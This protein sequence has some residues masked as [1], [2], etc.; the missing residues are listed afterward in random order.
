MKKL[1]PFTITAI[2]ITSLAVTPALSRSMPDYNCSDRAEACEKA[3]DENADTGK[4][5]NAYNECLE[6]CREFVRRCEERQAE[7]TRCAESFTTCIDRA[8]SELDREGC[9]RAYRRCKGD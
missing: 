2:V 4:N 8:Q 9:R 7:T 3:C 1:I 6:R 5:A